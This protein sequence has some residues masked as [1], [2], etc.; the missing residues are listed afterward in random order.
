MGVQ[1]SGPILAIE[2]IW[3]ANP[4]TE[5]LAGSESPSVTLF[6]NKHIN[7]LKIIP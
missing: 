4:Q 3:E 6:L 2:A 5:D 1:A 7:L